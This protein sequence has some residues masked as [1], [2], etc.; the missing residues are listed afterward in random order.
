MLKEDIISLWNR[1]AD[2]HEATTK[3]RD[4]VRKIFQLPH[5]VSIEYKRHD[6]SLTD[7]SSFR[8]TSSWRADGVGSPRR[9]PGDE[10]G[11][12]GDWGGKGGR[13]PP[14]SPSGPFGSPSGGGR[15]P[16]REW[17]SPG[18]PHQRGKGM[19][20]SPV[21][22][23]P[24]DRERTNSVDGAG[25]WNGMPPP[26][27]INS[28]GG[29]PGGTERLDRA[30]TNSAGNSGDMNWRRGTAAPPTIASTGGADDA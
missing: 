29:A 17:G 26:L 11:K 7:N 14:M 13:S 12:G 18:S 15:S 23:G 16:R 6:A 1:N 5:F 19:G 9:G 8:N 24:W 22:P 20:R 28:G 4:L 21:G 3:I 10:Y 25:G 27:N 2:N 30:R